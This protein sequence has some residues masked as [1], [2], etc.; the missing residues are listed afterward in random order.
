MNA[1]SD[2]LPTVG[3]GTLLADWPRDKESGRLIC[4]S[5]KPLPKELQS[6]HRAMHP[7]AVDD[8]DSAHYDYYRCPA[9]GIRFSVEVPE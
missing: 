8:G 3:V 6:G 1:Q 4:S 7:E 5:E 9:C 2:S